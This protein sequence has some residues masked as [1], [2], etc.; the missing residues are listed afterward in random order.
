MF[1]PQVQGPCVMETLKCLKTVLLYLGAAYAGI[2][3]SPTC[4][5]LDV[6]DA[7]ANEQAIAWSGS[8]AQHYAE[9][10]PCI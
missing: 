5:Y 10:A 7:E 4:T 9:Q 1:L 8:Y 6:N 2:Q 3:P